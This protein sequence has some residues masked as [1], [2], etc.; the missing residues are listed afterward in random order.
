MTFRPILMAALLAAALP[1]S[2]E[3]TGAPFDYTVG[4]TVYE[5][6]VARNT[7]AEPR[8]TVLIIHDWDGLGDYEMRRAEMLAAWATPR[9]RPIFTARMSNRPQPMNTAR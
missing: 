3:I 2:A 8:G 7:A 4:D 9:S 5:G 6:Y 1:A